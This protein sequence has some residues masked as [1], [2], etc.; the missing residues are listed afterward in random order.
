MQRVAGVAVIEE[1][2][3]A[4]EMDLPEAGLHRCEGGRARPGE[5]TERVRD[6]AGRGIAGASYSGGFGVAQAR[7]LGG[8]ASRECVARVRPGDKCR[9]RTVH[10]RRGQRSWRRL[11]GGLR[12]RPPQT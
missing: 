9:V 8:Q 6:G 10:G 1:A 12:R 3:A 5:S 7:T 4:G 11:D 2:F